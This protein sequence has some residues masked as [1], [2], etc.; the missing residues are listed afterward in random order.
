[1]SERSEH[2]QEVIHR[3]YQKIGHSKAS[4][5]VAHKGDILN[6]FDPDE[7][8]II[9][10][11]LHQI[12]GTRAREEEPKSEEMSQRSDYDQDVLHRYYQKVGASRFSPH[13]D[14][15]K[16]FREN[17][18]EI[19]RDFLHQ[20]G[21]KGRRTRS[22]RQAEE[23]ESEVEEIPIKI[24]ETKPVRNRGFFNRYPKKHERI[25]RKFLHDLLRE[26]TEVESYQ[27]SEELAF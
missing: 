7:Q 15:L 18:R 27:E 23:S 16:S 13:H 6:T 14:I 2:D 20:V 10:D 3:Y 22:K 5:G 21:S 11:F 19:I 24:S 17:E 4:H 9:R 12:R 8:K 26:G 25:I 1:M